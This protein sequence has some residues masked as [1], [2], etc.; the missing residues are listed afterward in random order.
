MIM[1]MGVEGVIGLAAGIGFILIYCLF[2]ALMWLF[3]R[4]RK[5]AERK[6]PEIK[7]PTVLR[8]A[9][10]LVLSGVSLMRASSYVPPADDGDGEDLVKVTVGGARATA[11]SHRPS[12]EDL[13]NLP[14]RTELVTMTSSEA[15]RGRG[16]ASLRTGSNRAAAASPMDKARDN[17]PR[18][19]APS[20]WPSDALDPS[21][22]SPGAAVPPNACTSTLARV[23]A[24]SSRGCFHERAAAELSEAKVASPV[25]LTVTLAPAVQASPNL[26]PSRA[27]IAVAA[28]T[29][30]RFWC[31]CGC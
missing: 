13:A 26:N 4:K 1:G 6:V 31:G 19:Y 15:S 24:G 8:S 21:A 3:K 7:A 25:I 29:N 11:P 10:E 27:G 23:R 17:V 18:E 16:R 30:Q 12:V 28:S 22:P 2:A 14:F 9:T 5:Q 20:A